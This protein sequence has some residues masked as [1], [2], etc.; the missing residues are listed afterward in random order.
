MEIRERL[1]YILKHYKW[2]QYVYKKLTSYLFRFVGLFLK[3]EDDL[4]LVNSWA[5]KTYSD[6]PKILYETM[7]KDPRFKNY[8]YQ[9]ERKDVWIQH[10][11]RDGG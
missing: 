8:R 9:G 11:H 3:I 7:I 5:G 4:I 2:I 6:S 1:V 10:C